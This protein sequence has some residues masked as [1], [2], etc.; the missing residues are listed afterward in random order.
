M[1]YAQ[2]LPFLTSISAYLERLKENWN[3]KA[4]I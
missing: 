2:Y 4:K 3:L 1:M